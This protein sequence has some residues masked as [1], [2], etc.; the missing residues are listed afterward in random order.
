MLPAL[1]EADID[2]FFRLVA[3]LLGEGIEVFA[4]LGASTKI[5]EFPSSRKSFLTLFG[6]LE[7]DRHLYYPAG[8]QKEKRKAYCAADESDS[9]CDEN[10]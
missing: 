9:A 4:G 8:N 2:L 5:T 1:E 10:F 6:R 3:M 7:L